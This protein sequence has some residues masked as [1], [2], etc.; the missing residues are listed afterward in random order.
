MEAPVERPSVTVERSGRWV[1]VA[2]VL[3]GSSLRSDPG[4]LPF[5]PP[6]RLS[7]PDSSGLLTFA[8]GVFNIF[9]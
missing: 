3:R 8:V 2:A 1:H 7:D 4:V 5:A 6:L 9:T